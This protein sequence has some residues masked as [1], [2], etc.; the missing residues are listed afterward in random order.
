MVFRSLLLITGLLLF[1]KSGFSQSAKISGHIYSA[2]EAVTNVNVNF[3]KS[4]IGVISDSTGFY[5]IENIPLGKKQMRASSIGFE[6]FTKEIN[7]LN[8]TTIRL[9]IHLT[10]LS[11][12][13]NE[14]VITG[15][16]KEIRWSESPVPVEIITPKLFQKNPT[17]SLFEAVGMLNGV[18]PQLNCNVCNTGDIHINGMEGPYTM[19]L[20]DGMP[21]VSALSTVYGLSGIPNSMVERIEVVKGPAS[22]LYGSEA[23]GGII[24]VIT[25]NPIRAPKLSTDV[26]ATSWGEISVDASAKFKAGKATSLIGL[27][28]FNYQNPIDNNNDNFTDVTLQNRISIF[29]KWDF[30]RDKNRVASIAGRYVYENR[31]GGEMNWSTKWRGSDSI[32]GESIYT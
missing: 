17:P 10:S 28:Y 9:D 18:K 19:I 31:W 2:G 14:V 30:R 6:T 32:Y 13:L 16:M 11:G 15:T 22:S 12:S 1:T 21:I 27:N 23:M 25:K 4:G 7:F 8:D 24:N 20:I 26:F 29:N 5:E 3:P